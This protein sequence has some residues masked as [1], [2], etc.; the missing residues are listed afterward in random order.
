[1]AQRIA[2]AKNRIH[3]A[4]I[5]FRMPAGNEREPRVAA[6]L[7]VLYLIFNEGYT[8]TSGSRLQR[9][10]L[11]VEAIRLARQ[12]HDLLPDEGEVAGVLALMLLTDARRDARTDETGGL[13]PLAEQDR[14]RWNR[15]QIEEGIALVTAALAQ[16]RVGPYQ[17]QAAIAAVHDEAA[18][19]EETRWPEVV[20]LYELLELL[21][22]NPVVTLN[23]A[24]AIAMVRGPRAGL[25]LLGRLDSEPRLA[26]HHRLVAVRAHLLEMAGSTDAAR[27]CYQRAARITTSIPERRYL[28]ARAAR[29]A[30]RPAEERPS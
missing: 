17:V 11:T 29:L 14:S 13:I 16:S 30:T 8:A 3:A 23:H 25:E 5:P 28:N 9:T 1:M 27:T 24:V 12:L 4:R 21:A 19:A 10:D 20:S 22:P 26:G 6:I 18:T 7:Q 15:A 2:R